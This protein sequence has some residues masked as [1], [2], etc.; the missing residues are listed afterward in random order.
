[1]LIDTDKGLLRFGVGDTDWGVA[2]EG[3]PN[4]KPVFPAVGLYQAKNSVTITRVSNSSVASDGKLSS[5]DRTLSIVNTHVLKYV[6]S[7]FTAS[8][9][10]LKHQCSHWREMEGA[11]HGFT[12]HACPK[13]YDSSKG[14]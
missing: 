11:E 2:H 3:L 10:D 13:V 1:M 6:N 12:N 7:L 8:R 9:Q 4:N 14:G 5:S